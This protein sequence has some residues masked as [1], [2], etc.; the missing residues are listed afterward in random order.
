MSEPSLKLLLPAQL[1]PV[2]DPLADWKDARLTWVQYILAQGLRMG[3]CAGTVR[4]QDI[5]TL[6]LVARH[7]L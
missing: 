4:L 6:F 7:H 5:A 1:R 2:L 3:I